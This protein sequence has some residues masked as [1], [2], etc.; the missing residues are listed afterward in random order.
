MKN[1]TDESPQHEQATQAVAQE[2]KTN[3]Q[4]QEL[5]PDQELVYRLKAAI[6]SRGRYS[7]RLQDMTAGFA[8]G[9]GVSNTIARQ[10]IEDN[11]TKQI[12][13]SPKEYLDRHYDELRQQ[14][15]ENTNGRSKGM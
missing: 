8:A 10:S 13:L 15:Q 3:G 4:A 12:G 2:R 1:R 7:F 11:F 6:D 9:R 14:G 5:N